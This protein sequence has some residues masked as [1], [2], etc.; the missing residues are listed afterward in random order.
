MLSY[1]K[2]AMRVLGRPLHTGVGYRFAP[3]GLSAG[4]GVY[5]DRRNAHHPCRP[6]LCRDMAHRGW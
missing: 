4:R 3:S 5:P 6:G 1:R 2:L